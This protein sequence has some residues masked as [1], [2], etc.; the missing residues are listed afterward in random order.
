MMNMIMIESPTK[1]T[2]VIC[3]GSMKR[4]PLVPA[5]KSGFTQIQILKNREDYYEHTHTIDKKRF[6]FCAGAIQHAA[7]DLVHP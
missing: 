1:S 3:F 6:L 5:L 7:S 4:I 2:L